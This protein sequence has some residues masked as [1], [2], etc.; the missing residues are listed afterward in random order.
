MACK[1]WNKTLDPEQANRNKEKWTNAEVEIKPI[2]NSYIFLIIC[3]V[4]FEVDNITQLVPK[5]IRQRDQSVTVNWSDLSRDFNRRQQD[6]CNQWS[7]IQR[8]Q[9]KRGDF[10]PQED[11]IIRKRVKEWEGRG[12]G[13]GVR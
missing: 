13:C 2:Y 7:I 1:R 8:S 5:Y 4:V 12:Q 6:C 10:S 3:C 9:M 11:A